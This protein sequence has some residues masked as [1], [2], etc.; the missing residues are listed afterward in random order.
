MIEHLS[1]QGKLDPR[2]GLHYFWCL[3]KIWTPPI[4][5]FVALKIIE[6]IIKLKK[7]WPP[8]VEGVKNSKK[9]P[10]HA[11]KAS[12]QT[13]KIIPYMLFCCYQSSKIICKTS[14]GVLITL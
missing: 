8:K 7:L 14:N 10:P 11:T 6:N 2:E 4:G 3:K 5:A 13:P 9:Q 1:T 12:S